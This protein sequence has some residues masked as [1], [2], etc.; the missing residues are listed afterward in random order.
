MLRPKEIKYLTD[1]QLYQDYMD[2]VNKV[3]GKNAVNSIRCNSGRVSKSLEE[4]V[5]KAWLNNQFTTIVS[6]TGNKGDFQGIDVIADKVTYQVKC[7]KTDYLVLEDCKW[8][9]GHKLPGKVDVCQAQW[10]LKCKPD[11]V[12]RLKAELY[13]VQEL[14]DFLKR[15]RETDTGM[16]VVDGYSFT[17]G[18]QGDN[19]NGGFFYRVY[20]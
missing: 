1:P 4:E 15:L 16:G 18:H 14:K 5:V 8:R 7:L 13:D 3:G 12:G 6:P 20:L 2:F 19:Q 11:G 17:Y 9:N 10:W